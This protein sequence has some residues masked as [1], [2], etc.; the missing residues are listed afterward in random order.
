MN[1]K[2]WLAYGVALCA[3]T[4]SVAQELPAR[5]APEDPHAVVPA[6][7]YNSAFTHY[8]DFSREQTGS[9]DQT[10]RTA[11]AAAAGKQGTEH[12][13][14]SGHG[15]AAATKRVPTAQATPAAAVQP[16]SPAQTGPYGQHQQGKR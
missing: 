6:L 12:L 14:H 13:D 3:P 1:R 7:Q 15:P 5:L 2:H 16:A 4:L 10:W 8:R 9:P 11:A